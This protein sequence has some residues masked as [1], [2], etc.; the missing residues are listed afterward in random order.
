MPDFPIRQRVAA[1]TEIT[2]ALCAAR[3]SVRLAGLESTD[4]LV[5]ELLLT[6]MTALDRVAFAA[7]RV[8]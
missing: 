1:L 4:F 7:R 6:A 8:I 2:D 3:C 5:R